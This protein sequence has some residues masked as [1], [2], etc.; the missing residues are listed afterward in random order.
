MLLS[1]KTALV[2]GA[3]QGMGEATA[4]ALAAQGAKVVV[5]DLDEEKGE[6][7]VDDIRAAGGDAFFI[8]CDV[9]ISEHVEATVARAVKVFGT[10]DCAVNNAAVLADH[11]PLTEASVEEFDRIISVNL[12][13]V[14]LGLK[15]QLRQMVL[16]G[17]G[18][19]VNIS[20]VNGLRA[21][22]SAAAYN[23]AKHAVIGLTRTAALEMADR[24]IR[25][26]A[27]CPGA[28]STPMLQS[29]IERRGINP[30][31]HARNLSPMGRFGEPGEVA[32]ATLWLC[33][34]A[35]SFVTGSILAVDG[36]H[37]AA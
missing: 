33:S 20:S 23:A 26:N 25:V 8:R 15:Y 5:A 30:A 36:G 12:R 28:I 31:E 2:T 4:K 17:S 19:V 37:H 1:E 24:N 29:A 16:Q 7:T 3:G 18:A 10:L 21:K 14:F 6:R 22:P 32:A 34:D 13:G 11:R 35:A 27:V 9:S